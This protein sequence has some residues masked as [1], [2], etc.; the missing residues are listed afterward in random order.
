MFLFQFVAP[1][2]KP[3]SQTV[4]YLSYWCSSES[5]LLYLSIVTIFS[6]PS[7][8]Y[9]SNKCLFFLLLIM[10]I[11]TLHF[12]VMSIVIQSQRKGRKKNIYFYFNLLWHSFISN[13]C[14]SLNAK[15]SSCYAFVI[16][17]HHKTRI[18]TDV[19]AYLVMLGNIFKL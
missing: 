15:H 8:H 13:F 11:F 6:M 16:F 7:L 18:N 2:L 14:C 9:K 3:F 1:F 12:R 5:F 17:G 10:F 19:W 4:H